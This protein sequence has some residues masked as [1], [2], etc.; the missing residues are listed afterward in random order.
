MSEVNKVCDD[1]QKIIEGSA[2]M[3][4]TPYPIIAAKR[5][6]EQQAQKIEWLISDDAYKIGHKDGHNAAF[7]TGLIG[8]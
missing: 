6:L 1:L 2:L 8:E 4:A 7:S 5:L 3:G